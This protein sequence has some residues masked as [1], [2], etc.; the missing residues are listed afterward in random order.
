MGRTAGDIQV[1]GV[2]IGHDFSRKVKGLN[3]FSGLAQDLV[4][5]K[6]LNEYRVRADRHI[7][8]SSGVGMAMVLPAGK[9]MDLTPEPQSRRAS[10]GPAWMRRLWASLGGRYIRPSYFMVSVWTL[11]MGFSIKTILPGPKKP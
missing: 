9:K 1:V 4:R 6:H 7:P 11:Y 3:N 5:R 8:A 2:R 10:S